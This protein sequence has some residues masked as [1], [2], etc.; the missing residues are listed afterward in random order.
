[1]SAWAPVTWRATASGT[2]PGGRARR[3][4]P[5]RVR[6]AAWP[7]PPGRRGRAGWGPDGLASS[8]R[9]SDGFLVGGYAANKKPPAPVATEGS[10]QAADSSATYALPKYENQAAMHVA[11]L[12]ACF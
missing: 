9:S 2:A 10:A 6:H 3:T 12:T 4:E 7:C 8:A 5:G 1:M 11:H